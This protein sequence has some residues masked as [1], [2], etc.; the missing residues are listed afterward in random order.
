VNDEVQ[1]FIA[2]FS[3]SA[4]DTASPVRFLVFLS[5]TGFVEHLFGDLIFIDPAKPRDLSLG[6]TTRPTSPG[7][8]G[9]ESM[10]Q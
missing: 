9:N 10:I 2:H 6:P 4:M 5:R 8:N 1:G 7:G 3:F